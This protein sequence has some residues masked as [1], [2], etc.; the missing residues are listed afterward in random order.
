M[1]IVVRRQRHTP[2]R[3]HLG[4]DFGDR[5][6]DAVRLLRDRGST[7]GLQ[8]MRRSLATWLIQLVDREA[9]GTTLATALTNV[10]VADDN[11]T[12]E[13]ALRLLA[14]HC[15]RGDGRWDATH[16]VSQADPCRVV[17]LDGTTCGTS[18]GRFLCGDA[19]CVG[20]H[21]ITAFTVLR[22]TLGCPPDWVA[23]P[24]PFVH[25]DSP[26]RR[27]QELVVT[28]VPPHDVPCW[29][30]L[31]GDPPFRIERWDLLVEGGLVTLQ[32]A[33]RWVACT[34]FHLPVMEWSLVCV[35]RDVT[36]AGSWWTR[37]R[38]S[39]LALVHPLGL[40]RW[41][42]LVWDDG[43]S[44]HHHASLFRHPDY[45]VDERGWRVVYAACE[46]PEDAALDTFCFC[47]S[48]EF[49]PLITQATTTDG[50]MLARGRRN[51]PRDALTLWRLLR[52]WVTMLHQVAGAVPPVPSIWDENTRARLQGHLDG[53]VCVG[54]HTHTPVG[55]SSPWVHG[56]THTVC[57]TSQ[58]PV[59][60][61]RP[62]ARGRIT[63]LSLVA[64]LRGSLGPTAVYGERRRF[65]VCDV[66]FPGLSEARV[67]R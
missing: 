62:M 36:V 28:R 50:W 57:V 65:L 8:R 33:V 9:D 29:V 60:R 6:S 20:P 41:E 18:V 10:L 2:L 30:A 53:C 56:S 44:P 25:P 43:L 32:A 23:S 45:A 11:V 26:F 12:A 5:L 39:R 16:H 52:R 40:E 22:D 27:F 64:G 55:G 51:L 13:D 61:G 17:P 48:L 1:V 21:H 37:R 31:S 54:T 19:L 3:V 47:W 38:H 59:I 66:V 7:R 63:W 35:P 15:C 46:E 67:M 49:G 4:R 14:H 34:V 24:L 42:A 58:H